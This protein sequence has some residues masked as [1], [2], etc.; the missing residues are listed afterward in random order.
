MESQPVTGITRSTKNGT[1]ISM[2]IRGVKDTSRTSGMC[3]CTQRSIW[4]RIHT[5]MTTPM[6]PPAPVARTESLTTSLL[7]QPMA[8]E[9][10]LTTEFKEAAPIMPPSISLTPNCLA[11]R[12]PVKMAM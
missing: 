7:Y 6:M 1:A 11:A 2:E 9:M 10:V 3:L 12:T 8:V 5:P 4:A